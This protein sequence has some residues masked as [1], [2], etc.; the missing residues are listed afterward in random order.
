MHM[1]CGSG[2]V[3]GAREYRDVPRAGLV[4]REYTA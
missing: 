4:L 1:S 2:T 3:V